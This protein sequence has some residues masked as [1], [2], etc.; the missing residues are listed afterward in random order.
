MIT[1]I[2]ILIKSLRIPNGI[3]VDCS[4]ELGLKFIGDSMDSIWIPHGL[5]HGIHMECIIP[6]TFHMDSIPTMEWKNS[7][8]PSQKIVHM[9]SMEWGV[10]SMDSIWIPYGIPRGV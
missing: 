9:E 3:H 8:G 1:I 5:V 10:E 7:R 4:I 2:I 6:W